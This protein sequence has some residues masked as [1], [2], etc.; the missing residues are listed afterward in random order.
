MFKGTISWITAQYMR[1]KINEKYQMDEINNMLIS[2]SV[3]G[4]RAEIISE[5]A[6]QIK[7]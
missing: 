6:N 4:K 3:Q 7:V 2:F 5:Q 1:K